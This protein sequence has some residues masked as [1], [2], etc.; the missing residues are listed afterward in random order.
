MHIL[1]DDTET[2]E[3]I[4][5][6]Y[7]FTLALWNL[8]S[9]HIYNATSERFRFNVFNII[10]WECPLQEANKVINFLNL[11]W[12]Q[13]IYSCSIQSK[14]PSFTG[15]LCYLKMKNEIEKWLSFK[16]SEINKFNTRW[17]VWIN[18]YLKR[19]QIIKC[20]CTVYIFIHKCIIIFPCVSA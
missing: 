9:I 12:K 3:H 10:F 1:W 17:A 15:L 6:T 4:F 11:I 8:F 16:N 2:I 18:I 5:A 19:D 20:I 7:T 14:L 13:Y